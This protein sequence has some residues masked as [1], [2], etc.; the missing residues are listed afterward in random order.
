MRGISEKC[1]IDPN[2]VSVEMVQSCNTDITTNIACS[3]EMNIPEVER[4]ICCDL[5]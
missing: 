4:S 3:A 5:E 1:T 2:C